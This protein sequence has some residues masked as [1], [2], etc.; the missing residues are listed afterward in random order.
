V[1]EKQEQR[2]KTHKASMFEV[3]FEAISLISAAALY[4]QLVGSVKVI[5]IAADSILSLL[6]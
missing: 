3:E 2:W 5:H 6:L 4:I 1:G